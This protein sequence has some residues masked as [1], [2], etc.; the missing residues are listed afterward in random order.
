[1]STSTGELLRAKGFREGG[2]SRSFLRVFFL[3]VLSLTLT[4]CGHKGPPVPPEEARPE[5]PKDLRLIP[6][7]LF[8]EMRFR[9]PVEDIRGEVLKKIKSFEVERVCWPVEGRGPEI[10]EFRK[11]PFGRSPS[12][13][14]E[15][16]W[17]ERDLRSGWCCR[18]R[19]RAIKGWRSESS[20]TSPQALCWHTP[21]R[22]PEDFTVKVLLPHTVYLSWKPV[23][24]DLQDFPLRYPVFYR[25]KRRERIGP[26][27]A[28][29]LIHETAFFDTSAQAGRTYCYSVE[30]LLS[31]YG[32]LVPGFSTPEICIR[33]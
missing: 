31:Y 17:R 4:W 1:M 6:H 32:T 30:P 16:V 18:W 22:T 5:A 28:F 19:V 13:L 2:V 9:P 33:P 12:R 11:I 15:F 25:I 8:V 10:Q 27:Q 3:V 20:W 7:P 29:P 24:R 14:K 26:P 23:R 21:P